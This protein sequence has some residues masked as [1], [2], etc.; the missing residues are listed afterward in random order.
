MALFKIGNGDFSIQKKNSRDCCSR[1]PTSFDYGN[2]ETVILGEERKANVFFS[3][4]VQRIRVYQM[5]QTDL[6]LLQ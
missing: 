1:T 4:E 2:K 6:L 5:W 3:W